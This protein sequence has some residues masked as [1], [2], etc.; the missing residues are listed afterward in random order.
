[1]G[2]GP[3]EWSVGSDGE[4]RAASGL[5]LLP[6]DMLKIGQI[7]LTGGMWN[8]KEVVPAEWV[9]TRGDSRGR[10][11]SRS[12]LRLSLVH[13]RRHRCRLAYDRAPEDEAETVGRHLDRVL[14]VA[15]VAVGN[16]EFV[17]FEAERHAEHVVR[18]ANLVPEDFYQVVPA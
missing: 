9:E 2:F 13:G 16:G 11:R 1:M 4:P 3:S 8:G 7:A 6:R 15:Q 5:R 12:Q 10:D 14:A 17:P 18:Q